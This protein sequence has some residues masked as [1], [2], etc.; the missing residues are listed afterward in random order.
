MEQTKYIQVLENGTETNRALIVAKSEVLPPGEFTEEEEVVLTASLST[1]SP[2]GIELNPKMMDYSIKDLAMFSQQ[3][4]TSANARYGNTPTKESFTETVRFFAG[5]LKKK[6][7]G[8]RKREVE[9]IINRGIDGEFDPKKEPVKHFSSAGFVK[10][11]RAYLEELKRPASAKKAQYDY[12]DKKELAVTK[13]EEKAALEEGLNFFI[14]KLENDEL[15]KSLEGLDA[16]FIRC[17]EL[18]VFDP[19]SLE[20]KKDIANAVYTGNSSLNQDEFRSICRKVAY[21]VVIHQGAMKPVVL[22]DLAAIVLNRR[23]TILEAAVETLKETA[24][25][26]S[27]DFA[28]KQKE[29]FQELADRKENI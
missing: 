3:K 16:V 23:K 21:L 8:L 17:E 7:G 10:W 26:N 18:G 24:Q 11:A 25:K 1:I 4:V 13:E 5:D 14:S 15:P 27:E 29:K 20:K 28:R 19:L 12:Q 9:A 6:F 2:E 22:P